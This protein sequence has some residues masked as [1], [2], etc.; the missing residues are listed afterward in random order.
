VAVPELAAA[1]VRVLELALA[2]QAVALLRAVVPVQAVALPRAVVPE[3][4]AA[5]VRVPAQAVVLAQAVAAQVAA[6]APLAASR[7]PLVKAPTMQ[8]PIG[9]LRFPLPSPGVAVAES[10]RADILPKRIVPP[11]LLRRLLLT[12]THLAAL[13]IV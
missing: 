1:P 13:L 2:R 5:P 6:R 9:S 8:R 12:G 11:P 10:T 7:R 4:A 3:L